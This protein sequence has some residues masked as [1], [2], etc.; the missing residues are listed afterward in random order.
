MQKE[1]TF[2]ILAN[3]LF[4]IILRVEHPLIYKHHR[5][6]F[7]GSTHSFSN[8]DAFHLLALSQ[9]G[10]TDSFSAIA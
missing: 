10:K 9:L 3:S 6:F 8:D 1:Y 7:A 4:K 2:S 5:I